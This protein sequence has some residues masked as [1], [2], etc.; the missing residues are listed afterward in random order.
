[1]K[2]LKILVTLV[3]TLA[4]AACAAPVPPTPVPQPLYETVVQVAVE[5]GDNRCATNVV[6]I[7]SPSDDGK[8][9][10]AILGATGGTVKYSLPAGE[11]VVVASTACYITDRRANST[12]G[13]TVGEG[14]TAFSVPATEPVVVK[15]LPN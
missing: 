8:G 9:I 11:Y 6:V 4:L 3:L 15:I 1:M 14:K 10:P 7:V 12:T 2:V 13:I 5:I